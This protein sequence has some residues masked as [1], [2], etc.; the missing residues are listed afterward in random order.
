MQFST[1][2][3][4]KYVHCLSEDKQVCQNCSQNLTTIS[5]SFVRSEL[6]YVP[7][8]LKVIDHYRESYECRCC[9]KRN[10]PAIQKTE[11]STPVIPH[12]YASASSIT[13]VIIQKFVNVVPLYRQESTWQQ[14]GLSLKRQTMSNWILHVSEE[15]FSPLIER[16]R[17]KL[18]EEQYLHADETRLEVLNE[19]NRKNTTSSFMWLYSTRQES[20]TPIRIFDYTQTRNGDHAKNFLV[21]FQ[22]Y[23]KVPSVTKCFCW[24]HLRRYFVEALPV[25]D[26]KKAGSIAEKA[27]RY[28]GHLFQLEKEFKNLTPEDRQKQ[29]QKKSL[30]I[31]RRFW[32]WVDQN[33][34]ACLPKSKL[35]KAFKYALNQKSGL[36]EFVSDRNIAISNNLAENSIRPFTIGRKNW[37]FAGSP[38]GAKASAAIYSLV[39]TAK[40]NGLNIFD[41]F[42]CLLTRMPQMDR[43]DSRSLDQFLPWSSEVQQYCRSPK[44][45]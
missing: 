2:D 43:D 16:L 40:A 15:Y 19:P 1:L 31:L 34:D 3:R 37:L 41:Y 18:L 24:S 23:E 45:F 33:A 5:Q 7:A 8:K 17:A 22:G 13:Q 9:K 30:P 21:G 12:S 27:I 35:F 25:N 38:R 20:T 11:T 42:N 39:E 10:L 32:L 28:C 26:V 36:M 29:R 44:S 14:A 4:E 6:V